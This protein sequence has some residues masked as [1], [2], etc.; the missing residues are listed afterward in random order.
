[1]HIRKAATLHTTSN[2]NLMKSRSETLQ[3]FNFCL[4]SLTILQFVL[5]SKFKFFPLW[6]SLARLCIVTYPAFGLDPKLQYH[7]Q[8]QLGALQRP[9]F[10]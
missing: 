8:N 7:G 4:I 10:P 2:F 5:N 3:Q 6:M 1:M 9:K